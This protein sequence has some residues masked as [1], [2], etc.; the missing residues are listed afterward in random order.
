MRVFL[1]LCF[2][3]LASFS[4][5]SAPSGVNLKNS[6][7]LLRNLLE[8]NK[9]KQ[10]FEK[11]IKE[12]WNIKSKEYYINFG[13]KTTFCISKKLFLEGLLIGSCVAELEFSSSFSKTKFAWVA[14]S[15]SEVSY[16][17]FEI[18]SVIP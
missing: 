15:A 1:I 6:Q 11:F 13:K 12:K 4:V 8:E 9:F 17:F 18:D 5:Q 14:I 2:T 10:E 3:T 16:S 7:V